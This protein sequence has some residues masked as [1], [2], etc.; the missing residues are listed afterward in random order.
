MMHLAPSY[1]LQD[2]ATDG[3][4]KGEAHAPNDNTR[5]WWLGR[6]EGVSQ[7]VAVGPARLTRRYRPNTWTCERADK[8]KN[9]HFG[10]SGQRP[11]IGPKASSPFMTLT[12]L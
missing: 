10:A 6:S 5:M 12:T 3:I 9:I 1:L 4:R 7:S 2:V 11:V 8:T